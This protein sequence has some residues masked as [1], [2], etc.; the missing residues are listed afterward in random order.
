MFK[1]YL[2]IV[3]LSNTY[4]RHHLIGKNVTL[5][6]K[7]LI[8]NQTTESCSMSF[9][10]IDKLFGISDISLSEKPIALIK[11]TSDQKS[12]GRQLFICF[13]CIMQLFN[14]LSSHIAELPVCLGYIADS[15]DTVIVLERYYNE[16]ITAE[17]FGVYA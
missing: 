16:L 14:K 3:G 13:K 11:K 17:L 1:L 4:F 7:S 15:H 5:N 6:Q 12:D 8:R 9:S 2:G 10:H